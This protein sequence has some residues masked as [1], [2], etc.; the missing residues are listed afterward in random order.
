MDINIF[1]QKS[2][3]RPKR[4][5]KREQKLLSLQ[6]QIEK[7]EYKIKPSQIADKI[8]Q[9]LHKTNSSS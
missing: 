9:T 4:L 1:P 8:L 3:K 6:R 7:G 2:Q 5:S